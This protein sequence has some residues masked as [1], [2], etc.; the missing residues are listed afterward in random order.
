MSRWIWTLTL[1]GVGLLS[2][3]RA[4][5]SRQSLSLQDCLHM[6]LRDHPDLA[7]AQTGVAQA[8]AAGKSAQ[9]GYLPRLDV[10]TSDSYTFVGRKESVYVESQEMDYPRNAYHNDLH[11]VGLYLSQ[12]IFDGFRY[13]HQPRRAARQ[14]DQA[15]LDVAV[16]RE[17]VGL[18]VMQAYFQLLKVE[19]QAQVLEEGLRLSQAQLDLAKERHRLGAGSRVDVS[20]ALVGMGEDRISLERQHQVIAQVRVDLNLALGRD[21]SLPIAVA[22]V[23]VDAKANAP[24]S[25]AR[26]ADHLQI[27]RSRAAEAVAAEDVELAQAGRWPTVS[28]S[29]SYSRQHEEFYKVYSRFNEL[30]SL[31][32]GLRIAYPIFDGF[33]AEAQIES[34]EAQRERVRR[35]RVVLRHGLQAQ[36]AKAKASLFHLRRV[37]QIEQANVKAAS[38][39]LLL[40]QERYDVGEG[41]ALEIRDAQLAMTRARLAEVQTRFDLH[42]AS[43]QLHHARGDL[44]ETYLDKGQP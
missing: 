11:G 3:A 26:L 37:G 21:P 35:Q 10:Q 38:D 9:A 41:T 6:A 7:L 17:A 16:T 12:N 25:V 5:S 44:L 31:N 42:I 4:D 33:A 18:R 40:A 34:A 13:I 30:Y 29:I 14:L 22:P 1:L 2:T 8:Q 20:K 23:E 28:G 15:E 36:L 39:S 32:F 24:V 27:E 43:A 19:H